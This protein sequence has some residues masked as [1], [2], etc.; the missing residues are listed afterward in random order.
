MDCVIGPGAPAIVIFIS[1]VMLFDVTVPLAVPSSF[2]G[3]VHDTLY[4]NLPP[5]S[6]TSV[7][8]SLSDRGH[9]ARLPSQRHSR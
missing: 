2:W 3:F 8:Q 1:I 4:E 7:W 5:L 6:E 9:L